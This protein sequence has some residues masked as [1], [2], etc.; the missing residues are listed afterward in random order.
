MK[1]VSKK[2]KSNSKSS[3]ILTV[4]LILL[5]LFIVILYIYFERNFIHKDNFEV[6]IINKYEMLIDERLGD[7]SKIYN[8]INKKLL[9]IENNQNQLMIDYDYLKNNDFRQEDHP[10]NSDIFLVSE[11]K[12]LLEMAFSRNLI[13]REKN[14][15]INLLR[16]ANLILDGLNY[17]EIDE[18][19]LAIQNEIQDLL[20]NKDN[21]E[22]LISQLSQ[23]SNKVESLKT[24]N[25]YSINTKT[26]V[27]STS[28][29][30]KL[31]ISIKEALNDVISIKKYD[32][33]DIDRELSEKIISIQLK[34]LLND[35]IQSIELNN[36]DSFKASLKASSNWIK[37]YFDENDN[38]VIGIQEKIKKMEDE[39]N[40]YLSNIK[41]IIN[42]IE[43]FEKTV[44][45]TNQ[46]P[47]N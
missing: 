9:E 35:A 5:S 21:N 41:G 12:Y 24:K 40:K 6:S 14:D 25:S 31:W 1:E 45:L 22:E 8:Q 42:L 38:E 37:L 44:L 39:E 36:T 3:A 30:Q 2:D 16:E 23:L 7:Q 10:N 15:I 46:P 47:M 17:K 29:Y 33:L 18:I 11:T 13:S 43:N 27:T 32:S 26:E 28:K 19:K 34:K 4:L 20:S